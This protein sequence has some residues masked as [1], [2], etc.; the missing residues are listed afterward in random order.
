MSPAAR[1]ISAIVLVALAVPVASAALAW[2]CS[3]QAGISTDRTSGAPGTQVSVR[4]TLFVP[5]QPVEIRWNEVNGPVLAT[6]RASADNS[7]WITA[8]ITIPS[9]S[10][11]TYAL[12]AVG[13]DA[14]GRVAG[15]APAPFTVTAPDTTAPTAPGR[16]QPRPGST[17]GTTSG[18]AAGG[19]RTSLR[20]SGGGG[21]RGRRSRSQDSSGLRS[22]SRAEA[23]PASGEVGSSARR[24]SGGAAPTS[25]RASAESASERSVGAD[26]WSGFL[27]GSARPSLSGTAGPVEGPG[28]PAS[29]I[30]ALLGLGVA[31]LAGGLGLAQLRRRTARAG[32]RAD[33]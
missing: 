12:V 31:A 24:A 29:L 20:A 14:Q 9:A 26:L 22:D 23:Q 4:G 21:E 7:A 30:V 16:V 32:A 27:P 19:G 6:T 3:K 17:A 11:D 18:D 33:S 2:A 28:S 25:G 1:R 15:T 10:A 5:G 13:R 8:T